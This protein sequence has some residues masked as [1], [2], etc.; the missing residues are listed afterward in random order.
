MNQESILLPLIHLFEAVILG[1]CMSYTAYLGTEK[2]FPQFFL[3]S[4]FKDD[5]LCYVLE[6]VI[7]SSLFG[8]DRIYFKTL[9]LMQTYFLGQHKV[10][11][12]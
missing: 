12:K 3:T 8:L 9:M 11:R 4:C 5:T 7:L 6:Y 10:Y 1:P 2:Y